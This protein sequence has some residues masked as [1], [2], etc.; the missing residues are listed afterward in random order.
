M[1]ETV[2]I[3]FVL[4]YFGFWTGIWIIFYILLKKSEKIG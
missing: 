1:L 3:V 2:I 4:G